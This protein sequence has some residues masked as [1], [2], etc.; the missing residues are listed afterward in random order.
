MQHPSQVPVA[1]DH[2]EG[3]PRRPRR[4]GCGARRARPT[5]RPPMLRTR[6]PSPPVRARDPDRLPADPQRRPH[7]QGKGW[8]EKRSPTRRSS[9]S[10]ST[11][12]ATS[13]RPSS[14]ARS[15][16]ASPVRAR[17]PRASRR[18]QHPL[19]GAVDLRRDRHQ[20]GAGRQEERGITPLAGLAGKKVATPFASTSHYSL[21]AALDNAGVAASRSRS[22]ISSRR[23]SS[24]PGQ[25][26][27]IDGAYVWTPTLA[28]LRKSGTTLIS[29]AHLAKKGKPTADLAVVR[30]ASPRSTRT[31]S[32]PGCPAEPGRRAV[33]QQPERSGRGDRPAAQPLAEE[34]LEQAKELVWLDA[35]EQATAEYLGARAGPARWREPVS[36]ASSSGRRQARRGATS[37]AFQRG[38]ANA[39]VAR[40]PARDAG[41]RRHGE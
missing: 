23:T 11:P 5:R 16:S 41:R 32:R 26:G 7:R 21:L 31:R 30:T 40:S 8:L 4:S 15:T 24:R 39:Y 3:L 14:P 36:A 13:T 29:S 28:E 2:S 19:Q 10:S 33:P 18:P 34:A 17:S 20:R 27:D 35:S 6:A 1:V 12:A 25:R 38:L 37:S 9:G 22:S